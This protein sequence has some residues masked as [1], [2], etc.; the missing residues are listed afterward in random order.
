MTLWGGRFDGE[1]SDVTREFTGDA[2]D[3]RLLTFDIL[4]GCII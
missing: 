2:S 1:M 4:G 3:R